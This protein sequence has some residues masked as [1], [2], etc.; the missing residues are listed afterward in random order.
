PIPPRQRRS[1][2]HRRDR[3]RQGPRPRRTPPHLQVRSHH[4]FT[5]LLNI[6]NRRRLNR[7]SATGKNTSA[8]ATKVSRESTPRN[9]TPKTSTNNACTLN[10]APDPGNTR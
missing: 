9:T 1:H 6:P 5:R 4:A 10:N 2:H 3:R 8:A 7:L